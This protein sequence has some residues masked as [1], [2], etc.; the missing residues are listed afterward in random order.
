MKP[1]KLSAEGGS[2]EGETRQISIR[3]LAV[4]TDSGRAPGKPD[5]NGG[6]LDSRS[7]RESR[8]D[9]GEEG[10]DRSERP[11]VNRVL[12]PSG[13][14]E[15]SAGCL[16]VVWFAEVDGTHPSRTVQAIARSFGAAIDRAGA[17]SFA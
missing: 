17:A 14:I 8:G 12:L 3:S 5:A 2:A 15:Q 4:S 10:D 6:A 1:K 13:R 11:G 9:R 16:E 7:A